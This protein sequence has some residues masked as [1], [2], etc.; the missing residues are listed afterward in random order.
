M[1]DKRVII[2]ASMGISLYVAISCFNISLWFVLLPGIGLGIIFGK[3][4]C[5]WVCPIVWYVLQ[6]VLMGSWYTE[7]K[8]MVL[9]RNYFG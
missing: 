2:L 8:L 9:V 7:V 5:R 1:V 6:P 4:F 3:V